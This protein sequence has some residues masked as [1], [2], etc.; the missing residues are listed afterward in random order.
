MSVVL[1]ELAVLRAVAFAMLSPAAALRPVADWCIGREVGHLVVEVQVR[2]VRWGSRV[3]K[4][5]SI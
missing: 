3:L 5:C 4:L 1:W 2:K